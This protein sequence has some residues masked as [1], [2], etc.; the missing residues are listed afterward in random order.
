ML[1]VSPSQHEGELLPPEKMR[2]FVGGGDFKVVGEAFRDYLV[3]LGG[4]RPDDRLLDVGCGCGRIAVPLTGYLSDKGSF[5]GF[6]I[7]KEGIEWCTRNITA[8]R[9]NFRF[10]FADIYNKRYNPLGR[11]PASSF[12]FPYPD[13]SFDFV[14]ASSVF[15]HLLRKDLSH[16]LSEI[17]RVMRTGGR[18]LITYFLFREEGL[19]DEEGKRNDIDFPLSCRSV[20]DGIQDRGGIRH[21]LR[22]GVPSRAL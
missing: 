17:R 20:P 22:R 7:Y 18:C 14:V 1:S 6:D 21:C 11:S 12:R 19:P 5:E 15:T 8:R 16:Y 3:N 10:R 9:P 4:L 13:E 2:E